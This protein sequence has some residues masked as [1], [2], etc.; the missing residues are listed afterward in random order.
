M[1]KKLADFYSCCFSFCFS[2]ICAPRARAQQTLGGIT[3]TVTD[4]SGAVIP[5]ATVTIVGDQTKLTRTLQ[6]YRYRQLQFRQS[7]H[8]QLHD[9]V[10]SHGLSNVEY[11]LDSGPGQP[12][13]H[14]K[15]HLED[16]RSGRRRSPSRRRRSSTPS[17]RPTAT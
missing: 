2:A 15:C 6:T 16:R 3:G 11:S 17:T 5:A 10:H 14:R 8:R 7:A 1:L 13:R 12:H 9:H 4:D